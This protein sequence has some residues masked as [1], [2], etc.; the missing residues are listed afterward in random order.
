MP[1]FIPV[2]QCTPEVPLLPPPFQPPT[3]CG[4]LLP[5][6]PN[7]Q[8]VGHAPPSLG[9]WYTISGTILVPVLT[10]VAQVFQ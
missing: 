1:R 6:T 5:L 3:A 4:A 2:M 10:I 8:A 7:Y 9:H